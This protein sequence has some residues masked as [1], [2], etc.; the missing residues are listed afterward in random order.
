MNDSK[1]VV[2]AGVTLN[3]T[4]G[5]EDVIS[6]FISKYEDQQIADRTSLQKTV[7]DLNNRIKQLVDVVTASVLAEVKEY[8]VDGDDGLFSMEVK[9][10]SGDD[11]IKLNWD[12]GVARI[13]LSTRIKSNSVSGYSGEQSGSIYVE[14]PLLE[15]DVVKYKALIVHKTELLNK[16]NQVQHNLRDVSRKERQVR[17][18]LAQWKLIEAGMG[19]L[20]VDNNLLALV[21]ESVLTD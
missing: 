4:I 3:A 12:T 18:V 20:L 2:L 1:S 7:L 10:K 16:L 21:S 6:V 13:V 8:E 11:G 17:G 14:V 5:M 19:E 15:E 9:V